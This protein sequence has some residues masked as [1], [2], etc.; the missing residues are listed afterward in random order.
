M[1]NKLLN[2]SV[3]IM[4]LRQRKQDKNCIIYFCS[5]NF[6]LR[7]LVV[8]AILVTVMGVVLFD[9]SADFIEGPIRAYAMD[10]CD[11]DDVKVALYYQALFTGRYNSIKV[12]DKSIFDTLGFGGAFGYASGGISWTSGTALG[13]YFPTDKQVVYVFAAFVFIVTVALNL[14]SIAEKNKV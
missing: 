8:P 7:S 6:N 3:K 5:S 14:I 10:V 13:R 4:E 1:A 11:E 12:K 9:F 2:L